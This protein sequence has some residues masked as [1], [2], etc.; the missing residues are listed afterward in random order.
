MMT[1]HADIFRVCIS[2]QVLI[3]DDNIPGPGCFNKGTVLRLTL[4]ENL[5]VPDKFIILL[6]QFRF[7]CGD[8]LIG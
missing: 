7:R 4:F 8:L 2:Y 5:F 3:I 6:A 1:T